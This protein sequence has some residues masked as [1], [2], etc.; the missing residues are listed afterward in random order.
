MLTTGTLLNHTY[1]VIVASV[2]VLLNG[3]YSNNYVPWGTIKRNTIPITFAFYIVIVQTASLVSKDRQDGC[4]YRER[5]KTEKADR[6]VAFC[7]H[8]FIFGA[9]SNSVADP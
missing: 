9:I 5:T 4:C 6:H 3:F 8:L 2:L 7:L 1:M